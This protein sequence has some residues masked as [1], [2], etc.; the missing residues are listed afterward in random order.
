MWCYDGANLVTRTLSDSIGCQ[1]RSP[2]QWI[3]EWFG[4]FELGRKKVLLADVF[5]FCSVFY[6]ALPRDGKYALLA[7]PSFRGLIS[8]ARTLYGNRLTIDWETAFPHLVTPHNL[9][10][11]RASN[12]GLAEGV[13]ILGTQELLVLEDGQLTL[14]LRGRRDTESQCSDLIHSGIC[15]AEIQIQVLT[16]LDIPLFLNLSGG[17]DSRMLFA[18]IIASGTEWAFSAETSSPLAAPAGPTRDILTK[19]L[20][21]TAT[22]C[23]TYGLNWRVPA[24]IQIEYLDFDGC[25]QRWQNFRSGNSFEI[26]DTRFIS[27][28]SDQRE[29]NLAGMGGE[30][31]RSYLG[32]NF[33]TG[34]PSWW[35]GAKKT[36]ESLRDD[37]EALF[38][39]IVPDFVM[40][41]ACI[42]EGHNPGFLRLSV[43]GERKMQ[44]LRWTWGTG[45]I[46]VGRTQES[47][48]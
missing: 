13:R 22:L 21:L 29:V 20:Q 19:D 42:G 23:A 43:S 27:G 34:Y 33:R 18:L 24:T 41:A 40:M 45:S 1:C 25:I 39:Y 10:R 6:F 32:A 31:V 26:G 2:L 48:L 36:S 9:F 37:L 44:S 47:R 11:T 15:R 38:T 28:P 30:L 4:V 5:G 8:A 46:E 35:Q 12:R 14:Y 16:K 17:K 3:G 7:S